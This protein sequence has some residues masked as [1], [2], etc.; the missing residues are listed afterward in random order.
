MKTILCLQGSLR[1]ASSSSALGRALRERLAGKAETPV[2][3][4]ARLPHYNSDIKD[5][6]AVAELIAAIRS[7]DGVLF[8]TPEYNYS[9]PGHLKNAID[10]AS[11][12]AYASVFKGKPSMVITTSGGLMGGVR[13]QSHLKYIL[14]GMLARI[15]VGK[16]V[17]V[18][19]ANA[20][21]VDGVF[22]DEAIL[23]F[24]L[25]EAEAFLASL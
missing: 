7:A 16:E 4:T 11:R 21:T 20:K 3:D 5:D 24:A 18:P 6:P 12:P 22:G 1:T 2:F 15:H 14:N 23:V 19:H 13:A 8:V 9:V 10:W 25:A 17:I